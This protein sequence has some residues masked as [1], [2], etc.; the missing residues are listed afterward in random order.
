MPICGEINNIYNEI[1]YFRRN[2]FDIPS[3]SAGKN[4]IKELTSW[5][6]E[7][8]SNS[9]LN[10]IALKA[11]MVLP[12]MSLPAENVGKIISA[13]PPIIAYPHGPKIK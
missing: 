2:I 5:Q 1:A 7:F 10:S 9:D 13:H 4:F 6:K 12:K 3:G 11:F 8:N